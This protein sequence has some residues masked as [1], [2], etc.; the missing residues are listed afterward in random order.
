MMN[1]HSSEELRKLCETDPDV[2]LL[3]STFK[4]LDQIYQDG[5][6]ALGIKVKEEPQ[7]QNSTAILNSYESVSTDQFG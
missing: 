2:A 1:E 7:V 4:E 6:E 5:L 3:I